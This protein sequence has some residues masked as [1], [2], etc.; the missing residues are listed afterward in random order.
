VFQ[1]Q[2]GGHLSDE[3]LLVHISAVHA[4]TRASYGWPRIWRKLLVRGIQVGKDRVQ[5]LM[6]LHAIC[7]K[8]KRRFKLA[9]DSKHALPIAPSQSCSKGTRRGGDERKTEGATGVERG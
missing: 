7:A 1:C 3:V 6:Q 5:K 4:E 9:T 8:G 2:Q